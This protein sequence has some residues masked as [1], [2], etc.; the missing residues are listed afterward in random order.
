MITCLMAKLAQQKKRNIRD[1]MVFDAQTYLIAIDTGCSFCITNDDRHFVG[2]V[3]TVEVKVNGIGGKQVT[4]NKRGT[5]RWSY[6]NDEGC[7]YDHYI[8]NTYYNKESPYCL[9]SPQHVAQMA[10]DHYP[11]RNGTCITTYSDTLVMMWE[12]GQQRRTVDVDPS[13]NIFL[14]RSAPAFEKFHAFNSTI[15]EIDN[16]RYEMHS[17]NIVS[18]GESDEESIGS[19]DELD[20]QEQNELTPPATANNQPI[21]LEVARNENVHDR[22]HPD[23]PNTAFDRIDFNGE[24]EMLPTEDVDIQANTSQAK[25]LAWHYRLGHIPFAKIRQMASRGDLPIGLATCQIPKCAACMYGK[26]TRRAWRTKTPVNAIANKQ[27]TAPGAVVSMDQLVSAVPGLIG[28]MKGFLTRKRYMVATVFVDHFSGMS[29]VYLQKGATALETIEAKKAFERFASTH[30][31]VVR[32]YHSDNGIFETREFQDEVAAC[33]QTISFCGVNAHH[34]NGKAEKKIRDLQELTRTMILHAQQRWSDAINAYL[35]P[36]AMKM[37]NDISNRAPGI[38]TGVSPIELFSQVEVSPRVKHSHTFGAPVYVLDNVL[39]TPG[40]GIPKWSKR[41][42]V[43]IYVGISPRHSRKIALVL[44]LITGHVSP[45]FHV[46]VDDFFETLRISAGNPLPKSDW[47]KATGFIRS[48][49]HR[50]TRE[51]MN[52]LAPAPPKDDS[53]EQESELQ[54]QE[55]NMTTTDE[56]ET[57]AFQQHPWNENGQSTDDRPKP[58]DTIR[59]RSGRVSKPTERMIESIEQQMNGVVS[60]FVEWEVYHDDSYTIQTEMENPMAFV[61]ST[62]PDVMYLDQAMK[63]P[64]RAKFE[65]AMLKE[66]KAHT[67]NGHWKIVHK[68]SIPR[69]TKILPAVWAMRRKRKIA[70]GEPYKWK[71]RLNVHGGK[72]EYGINYWETYAPVIAWATIRLYLI[73]AILNKKVTRQIDFVLAFPQ[74]D[75]ECDLYMEIPRGFHFEG[76]HADYCLLLVANLYGQKQAGRVWNQYLDDGLVARGF[77]QSKVDMCLYFHPKY[78]VSL[79][80]YTD[81]G[82]LTGDSDLDIDAVIELLRLP[83]GK[84]GENRAFEMTDEGTLNDYL[85]VKVEHMKDGSIKLS[86]PHLIQQIIND[87]GFNDQTISKTTPAAATV[88]LGRDLHGE[89]MQEAWHYRSIIGKLNFLEKSTRPDIAYAVHQCARFANDPKVS[90]AAAV[91]RIVKYLVGT[92]DK[93]IYLRPDNHSFECWVDADFVGNW[94]RVNADVD[95]S[96]AKSRTGYIIN[97]GGCPITWASKLQTEVALST[98]EAEYNALSTSLREV[99]HLMHLIDEAKEKGWTTVDEAPKIHCKVFEDNIGALEMARLP[100]MRPR[101]KHLCIRLHHFREK[102]HPSYRYG[103]TNCRYADETTTCRVVCQS[104]IYINEVAS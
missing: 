76:S 85:G 56:N 97:Y 19:L 18:D 61:A 90:H 16:G 98:T 70:T 53:M 58:E 1:E 82:I 24:M 55:E 39:Q 62:N 50:Q 71:A 100:K 32:H 44:N 79:M 31:V 34:Q 63:E 21:V 3:E 51:S 93:G 52:P 92:K 38:H 80:I 41:A 68:R 10:N 77:V 69:G 83:A 28:Q 84:Q 5:V 47:Q 15:E 60:L 104:T 40:I 88:K 57:V 99:I 11:D 13:T 48:A 78:N 20:D 36:F 12:Q 49:Q 23:I 64:D 33:Q 75:S 4:A 67:D 66:V 102:V 103:V 72:Q 26:A 37:A 25:L 73:L 43:G 17:P 96:T 91:K 95:P 46:V 9:L 81:D 101:T 2:E 22:R 27:V 94:D 65:E 14:M 42:N 74:A 54:M 6:L 29:Y 89:P 35:W 59:T 7:V 87:I 8:P 86:Q 45:Q 30:G